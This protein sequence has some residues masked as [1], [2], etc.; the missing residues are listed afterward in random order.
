MS[1]GVYAKCDDDDD[2]VFLFQ[3]YLSHIEIE[4]MKG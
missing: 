2:L 4:T 1:F 3:H